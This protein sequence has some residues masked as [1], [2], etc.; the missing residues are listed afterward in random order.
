MASL[1]DGQTHLADEAGD[2]LV[3]ALCDSKQ[4]RPLAALTGTP[5]DQAQICPTCYSILR[6]E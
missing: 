6:A 1:A 4:F 3:T 2:A 5:P